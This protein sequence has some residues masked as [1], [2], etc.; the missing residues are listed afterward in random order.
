[1]KDGS[2]SNIAFV[3]TEAMQKWVM[4]NN[5]TFAGDFC[6]VDAWN[7]GRLVFYVIDGSW[8]MYTTDI[9]ALCA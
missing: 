9:G 1:M 2:G 7:Y 8:V 4:D 5:G 6:V 3:T